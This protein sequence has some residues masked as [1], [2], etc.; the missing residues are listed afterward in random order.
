MTGNERL[1]DDGGADAAVL[2]VVQVAPAYPSRRDVDEGLVGDI[3]GPV[4]ENGLVHGAFSVPVSIAVGDLS[5]WARF[6]TSMGNSMD[7][8]GTADDLR[9]I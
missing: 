2:V 8:G 1:M 7:M 6:G 9:E 4:H 5:C 3:P